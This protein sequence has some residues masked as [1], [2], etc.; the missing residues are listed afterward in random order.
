MIQNR[1]KF[2]LLIVVLILIVGA[3]IYLD[4]DKIDYSN[5]NEGAAKIS[6]TKEPSKIIN[7]VEY[8]LSPELA[9][10]KDYLNTNEKAIN[11]SDYEGK[12]VLIDFWT[13]TCINCIRT[14]P[15]I[16]SWDDKYRDK[17]LVIIGVHS[18]EFEFEKDR[19]NV[20]MAIE[21]YGIKYPV[22]LDNQ[23]GTWSAFSNRYWPAKYLI[24]SDGYIRYLHF[25]E[26]AYEETE[27]KIQELLSE[28]GYNANENLTQE[29][30]SSKHR[31][32]P[33]LYAGALFSLQ[34]GQYIGN[35]KT[36]ATN[37]YY[38]LPD[39]LDKDIIYLDGNW[40]NEYDNLKF[41]GEN[42]KIS[43]DFTASEINIVASPGSED[44][45]EIEVKVN[46]N[47]VN[48]NNAGSDV[49]FEGNRAYVIVDSDR[50]YNIYQ[51]EYGN[52]RLDLSVHKGFSFNAFTFG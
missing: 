36:H 49:I 43:L 11:I 46:G 20:Q 34:R 48:K 17:G 28:A 51:G 44:K 45:V 47:Y 52:Y 32:T 42:G 5:S 39:E 50:L 40:T 14:L 18:P 2:I 25:G 37:E 3:I 26:G 21:K 15:Y 4:K 1:N 22:V 27:M 7:G 16:T 9:G 23:R 12:V 31:V 13:Y 24:D 35:K 6:S 41:E 38:E 33:E 10:I 29:K 19:N 30:E 8:P